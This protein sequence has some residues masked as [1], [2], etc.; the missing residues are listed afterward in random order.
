MLSNWSQV[1]NL[2]NDP[3]SCTVHRTITV[4]ELEPL[5][6]ELAKAYAKDIGSDYDAAKTKLKEKLIAAEPKL[7]GATVSF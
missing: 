6:D 3:T 7:H 1:S 4:K 5:V 2:Q